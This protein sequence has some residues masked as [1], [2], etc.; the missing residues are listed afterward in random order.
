MLA[1]SNIIIVIVKV[2]K[3]KCPVGSV[4]IN[5][6]W[7][8]LLN[9]DHARRPVQFCQQSCKTKSISDFAREPGKRS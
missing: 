5:D 2:F 6:E 4:N 3:L 8:G 9:L 7:W 1:I